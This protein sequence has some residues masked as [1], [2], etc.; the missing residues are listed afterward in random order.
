MKYVSN[1]FSP[2]M[3]NPNKELEI[4]I[5]NTTYEEIQEERM[6]LISSIG[7]DSIAE[8]LKMDKNRI[9]IQLE[10]DDLLY[11]V[12]MY[13]D[14]KKTKHYDYRKIRIRK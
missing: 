3:L 14:E 10:E 7:H 12:Q 8:H 2:K 6:E 13:H 5:E 11:L 9:N 1:G 4:T